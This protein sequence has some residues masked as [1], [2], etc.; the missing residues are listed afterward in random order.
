MLSRDFRDILSAL[1]DAGADYLLV[2]AHA[3]AAHGLVRATGDIDVWVRPTAEN[4]RKVHRALLIF[5][6]PADQFQIEDL[7]QPE[8]VLQLGVAPFRIDILTTISGVEFSEA[9]EA[10]M[11]IEMDGVAVPLLSRAHLVAN[12]RASKRPKDQNDLRWLEEHESGSDRS[13]PV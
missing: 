7:T 10:R 11:V 13:P 3:L 9:W 4:A 5:G 2:G 12:K 1:S 8:A 6:A